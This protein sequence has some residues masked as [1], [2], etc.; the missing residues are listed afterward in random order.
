MYV[1]PQRQQS[2]LLMVVFTALF[3]WGAWK[4]LELQALP[5][6]PYVL[7]FVALVI[8][9][10]ALSLSLVRLRNILMRNEAM[11]PTHQRG[12][13]SWSTTKV[14]E[15]AR[16][17]ETSGVFLGCDTDGRPLFFDGEGHGLTLAPSGAGKTV[18]FVVPAL[19]HTHS[20]LSLIVTDF[21]ATLSV[22]TK[23][24]RE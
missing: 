1:P 22:M 12:S 8:G 7:G 9:F 19:A 13:A 24:L 10:Q 4:S 11:E 18:G 5:L 6:I 17:Y 2:L 23:T 20:S 16:L 14:L 15:R 3:G 21:K